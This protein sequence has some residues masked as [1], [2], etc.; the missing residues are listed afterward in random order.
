MSPLCSNSDLI[1]FSHIRWDESHQRI[2]HLM[3]RYATHRR[4]YFV[5]RPQTVDHLQPFMDF[6]NRT[7]IRLLTPHVPLHFSSTQRTQ[8]CRNFMDDLIKEEDIQNFSLWYNDPLALKFTDHL[9]P[10]LTI[11]DGFH[12]KS[13]DHSEYERRLVNKADLVLAENNPP[14]RYS[15]VSKRN[16]VQ[17]LLDAEEKERAHNISWDQSWACVAELEQNAL[18]SKAKKAKIHLSRNS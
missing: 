1:V 15:S 4:I 6:Q 11:Y 13:T 14:K 5:E 18:T 2:H 8:I 3:T 16:L 7:N 9:I 10:S 12:H 17:Y